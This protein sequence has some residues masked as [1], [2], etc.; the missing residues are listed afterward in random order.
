MDRKTISG[1][2]VGL[3]A[4]DRR[5]GVGQSYRVSPGTILL[6]LLVGKQKR[7][8]SLAQEPLHIVGQQAQKDMG[9][10][11]VLGAVANRADSQIEALETAKGPF[12][13]S[14]ALVATHRVCG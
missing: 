14:Q 11:M 5:R 13:L 3:L 1:L 10:N 6:E 7:R 2:T 9:P 4:D 12:D 8:P